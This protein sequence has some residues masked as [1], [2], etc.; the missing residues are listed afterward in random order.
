MTG[1]TVL[2]PL[3][4]MYSSRAHDAASIQVTRDAASCYLGGRRDQV[5]RRSMTVGNVVSG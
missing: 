3:V 4:M 1:R 2:V 5:K